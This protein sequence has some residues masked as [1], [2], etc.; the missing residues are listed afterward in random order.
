MNVSPLKHRLERGAHRMMH[1]PVPERRR[2]YLA[3]LGLANG[4]GVIGTG[5]IITILK[6]MLQPKQLL[7]QVE[8]E[9]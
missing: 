5:L 6:F 8:H 7:L 1:H 4:E 3:F 2:R 9:P